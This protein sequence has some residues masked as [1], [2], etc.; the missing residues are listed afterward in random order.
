MFFVDDEHNADCLRSILKVNEWDQLGLALGVKSHKLDEI[1][2]TQR[3]VI[4][5]CRREMLRTWMNGG[6]NVTWHALC[7]ALADQLVGHLALAKEIAEKHRQEV[8][9]SSPTAETSGSGGTK[10]LAG[11]SIAYYDTPVPPYDTHLEHVDSQSQS[12]FSTEGRPPSYNPGWV[13][14]VGSDGPLGDIPAAAPGQYITP[15]PGQ[16][17]TAGPDQYNI[18]SGP[19]QYGTPGPGQQLSKPVPATTDDVHSC[20]SHIFQEAVEVHHNYD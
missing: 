17:S 4:H 7:I 13:Q 14:N 5:D 15:R 12:S 20:T 18:V 1:K 6:V 11:K 10:I 9:I 3:Y 2:Q 8:P 19:G 16:Y